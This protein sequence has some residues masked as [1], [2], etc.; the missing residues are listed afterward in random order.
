MERLTP[1]P[2]RIRHLTIPDIF[3]VSQI[4]VGRDCRLKALIGMQE[5]IEEK[6]APNPAAELGTIYH[7]LVE[8][9]VRKL[10]LEEGDA[11]DR[12]ESFL[13]G[14]LEET[15]ARLKED[16]RTAPYADLRETMSPKAWQKKRRS[17]IDLAR[18][19]VENEPRRRV[20]AH[21]GR[22]GE[23]CFEALIANGRWAEV[24]IAVPGLRLKGRIDVLE[25]KGEAIKLIKG[26]WRITST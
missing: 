26:P 6:L 16:P 12:L 24:P 17:F 15:Q 11:E 18:E 14:L 20:A 23:F 3:S 21:S 8:K 19:Y 9:A 7:S 5:A 4:A 2:A 25:R 1:L 22:R 13:D 10:S